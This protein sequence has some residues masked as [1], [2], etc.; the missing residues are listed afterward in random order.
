MDSEIMPTG[1]IELLIH[2]VRG[3]RVILDEDIATLYQVETR[4]LVQAVQR[5]RNR[6]PSDF[7]F[8]LTREEFDELRA[9]LGVAGQH[10]GRRKAP[11]AFTEHGV[12]MLSG[13][14]RSE[15]AVKANV[16]VIRAFVRMRT[17][18]TA[19]RELV[20]RIDELEARYDSQFSIVFDA[21]RQLMTPPALTRNPFGFTAPKEPA[22]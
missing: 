21:I 16:M 20:T 18:I 11:Y 1:D 2:E 5:N 22:D 14:L 7:M 12:A 4:H 17:V 3:S 10:G 19:H 6:F 8:R 15:R 13:V 9:S